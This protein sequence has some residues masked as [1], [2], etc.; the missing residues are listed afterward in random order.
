M[1]RICRCRYPMYRDYTHVQIANIEKFSI[2][3]KR[4]STQYTYLRESKTHFLYF[5]RFKL[6]NRC[7]GCN[8][9]QGNNYIENQITHHI[10]HCIANRKIENELR[11]PHRVVEMF[12][13]HSHTF[14]CKY[15]ISLFAAC[16]VYRYT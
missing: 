5:D 2:F 11:L 15:H 3:E 14:S 4:Q 6:C 16:N 12:A 1:I 7:N 13:K 9:N 8:L 10:I